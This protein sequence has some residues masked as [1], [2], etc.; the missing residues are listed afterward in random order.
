MARGV[1]KSSFTTIPYCQTSN[2][3]VDCLKALI[4]QI[5]ASN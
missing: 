1:K 4:K 2:E 3:H 5:K